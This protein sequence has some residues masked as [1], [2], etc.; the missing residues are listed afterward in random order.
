M[1]RRVRALLSFFAALML[2][3]S[4]GV[5][6]VAHAGEPVGC[7]DGP[8]MDM[9]APVAVA[10]HVDCGMVDV[11]AD[12]DKGYPH[13]HG[14]CH[15]HQIAAMDEGAAMPRCR[16]EADRMTPVNVARLVATA[17]ATE[18]EPPRA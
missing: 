17:T 14:T 8:S 3:A 11:P 1:H 7:M 13:H 5:S 4:L 12:A 2:L 9:G 18:M 10:G 15:G 6:T 16:R